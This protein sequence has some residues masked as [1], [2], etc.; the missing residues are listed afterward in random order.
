LLSFIIIETAGCTASN[1]DMPARALPAASCIMQLPS[2]QPLL[3]QAPPAS[4]PLAQGPLVPALPLAL[5]QAWLV[6][7]AAQQ[8]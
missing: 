1:N 8:S 4:Q 6:A 5:Q 2:Q 7:A 3:Q